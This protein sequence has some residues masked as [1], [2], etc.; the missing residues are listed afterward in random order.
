ML[1]NRITMI[2]SR[3]FFTSIKQNIKDLNKIFIRE[4]NGTTITYGQMVKLSSQFS[5][6]FFQLGLEKGDRV[7]MYADKSP[8]AVIV[9]VACL[10]AGFVFTPINP[11]YTKRELEYFIHDAMPKV[12]ISDVDKERVILKNKRN[13]VLSGNNFSRREDYKVFREYLG[14]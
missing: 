14:L 11:T 3:N 1:N 2:M 9:Y 8:E 5:N 12:I 13:S 7:M 4:P 6:M 10:R